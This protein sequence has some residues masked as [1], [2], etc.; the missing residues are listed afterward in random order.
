MPKAY[1]ITCYREIK[2]PDKVAAYAKLAVPALAKFGV[3]YLCR[4]T[5]GATF[6]AGLKERMVMSE[7]RASPRRSPRITGRTIRR[8]S[9]RSATARCAI[10]GLWRGW[11]RAASSPGRRAAVTASDPTRSRVRVAR[12][13]AHRPR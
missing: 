9:R 1:W 7:C 4:G 11:S 10:S 6:E 8:R 2:D 3:R 5:P 13:A 12:F